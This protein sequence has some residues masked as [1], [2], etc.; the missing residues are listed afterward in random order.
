MGEPYNAKADIWALGCILYEIITGIRA[1]E[2]SSE[3]MLK[4]R[5]QTCQ[6]PRLPTTNMSANMESL[7]EVFNLCMQKKQCDRPSVTEI[8]DLEPV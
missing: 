6:V 8:L 1:F 2:C 5:I 3:Q 4:Q 7:R